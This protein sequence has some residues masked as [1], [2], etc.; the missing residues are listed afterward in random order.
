[1]ALVPYG[2]Q[3]Y[4][5]Q[6]GALMQPS[7]STGYGYDNY[8]YGTG[9]GY[10]SGYGQSYLPGGSPALYYPSNR[11]RR[12]SNR[13]RVMYT[14]DER[15]TRLEDVVYE[16]YYVDPRYSRSYYGSQYGSQYDSGYGRPYSYGGGAGYSTYY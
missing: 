7:M 14:D 10:G 4:V 6:P 11:R 3:S 13:M 9:Y 2:Q 12:G 5:A 8:G 15:L 1:M 16:G